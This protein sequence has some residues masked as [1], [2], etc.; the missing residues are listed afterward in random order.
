MHLLN[1]CNVK[2]T[3]LRS[4]LCLLAQASA[5][6]PASPVFFALLKLKI[7]YFKLPDLFFSRYLASFEI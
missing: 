1:F 4:P 2:N 6:C 7:Y 3:F 5:G